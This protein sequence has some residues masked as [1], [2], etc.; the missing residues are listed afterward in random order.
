MSSEM[1]SE[2]SSAVHV[3]LSSTGK[4][5]QCTYEGD[6]GWEIFSAENKVIPPGER[7]VIRT[8]V[9]LT[10]PPGMYCRIS[11]YSGLAENH[12][13][14]V[15]AGIVDAGYRGEVSVVMVNHDSMAYFYVRP[16]QVVAKLVFGYVPAVKLIRRE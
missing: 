3:I 15:L 8:G 12:G 9:S 5:P 13:I 10:V 2:T 14:D 11:P 1:S 16:G 4:M 7:Q 6:A